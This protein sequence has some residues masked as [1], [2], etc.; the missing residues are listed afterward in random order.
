MSPRTGF[1]KVTSALSFMFMGT[2]RSMW[3]SSERQ[4]ERRRW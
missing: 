1:G 4:V 3:S 2:Q